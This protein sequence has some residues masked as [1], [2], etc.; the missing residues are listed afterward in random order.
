VYRGELAITRD[1]EG[2]GARIEVR[3]P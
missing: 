2:G 3:L 1:E